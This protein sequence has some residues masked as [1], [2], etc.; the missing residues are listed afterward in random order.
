[1]KRAN[2]KPILVAAA[3][4]AAF[5]APLAGAEGELRLTEAG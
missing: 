5:W 4:V 3:L 2:W 1:M